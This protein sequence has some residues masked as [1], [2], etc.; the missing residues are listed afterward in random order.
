MANI[1][2]IDNQ[3]LSR[4]G[5]KR[6]LEGIEDIRIVGETNDATG[7]LEDI[8]S[9]QCDVV[10]LEI[11]LPDQS[12]LEIMR[13]LRR[14]CPKARCIV[15][16]EHPESRY[17]LRA[18]RAGAFG[19][20][21]K[22]ASKG[23]IVEAIRK[24]AKGEYSISGPL[25]KQIVRILVDHPPELPHERLSNREFEILRYL[26]VGKTTRKIA[27]DL[28]LRANS[29]AT[30]KSRIFKKLRISSISELTRYAL[31]KDLVD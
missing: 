3:E 8:K 21:T 15:F 6:V 25:L 23:Q 4:E 9:V 19:Y 30:Y 12:G 29:V 17:A 7:L 31:E 5:L 27:S 26:A 24:V 16:S 2:I 13:R 11:G 28:N 10:V 1:F 14:L 18:I 22:D 20:L